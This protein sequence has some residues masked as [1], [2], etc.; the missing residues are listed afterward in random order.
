MRKMLSTD[1]TQPGLPVPSTLKRE[2]EFAD[3]RPLMRAASR[4]QY[5][6]RKALG[7]CAYF[8]CAAH[9][10]AGRMYCPSHLERMSRCNRRRCRERQQNG[11]CIYCGLRPPFW[12]VRCLVCRQIFVKGQSALPAGARR[13]LRLYREDERQFEL[14]QLQ[15]QTRFAVRKLLAGGEVTGDRARALLLYAGLDKGFWR[16]YREVGEVMKLSRERVRQLLYPSK[17]ELVHMLGGNVPWKPLPVRTKRTT[18]PTNKTGGRFHRQ[19]SK[20]RSPLNV[21]AINS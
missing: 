7:L 21:S 10:K 9:A 16:T 6:K 5:Q 3:S 19:V 1:Q 4:R 15:V 2:P 17:V 12:G 18:N 14:E 8:G 11:L 13:A 20:T